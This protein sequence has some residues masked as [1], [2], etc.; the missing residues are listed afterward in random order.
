MPPSSLKY[1]LLVSPQPEPL[2]WPCLG[3]Q[4]L[5]SPQL[6]LAYCCTLTLSL[7]S[8]FTRPIA[9]MTLLM[10][11][12]YFK[13][14]TF[15]AGL[16]IST[17]SPLRTLGPV[18]LFQLMETPPPSRCSVKERVIENLWAENTAPQFQDLGSQQRFKKI[19]NQSTKRSNLTYQKIK[20]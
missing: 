3:T 12:A 20:Q 17:S 16:L 19:K 4:S 14:N 2:I 5:S 7:S 18:F 13:L 6:V 11:V 8:Q 15:S 9:C 10:A 1:R